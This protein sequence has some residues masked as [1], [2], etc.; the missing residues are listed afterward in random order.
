MRQGLPPRVLPGLRFI[1]VRVWASPATLLGLVLIPL[2]VLPGGSVRVVGGVLEVH[3]GLVTRLLRIGLPWVGPVAALTLGHVVLGC[4]R[5][6]LQ[7][8]RAHERVHVR[9]YERWGPVLIPAYLLAGLF[10]RFRG[11]DPYADNPFEKEAV[12]KTLDCE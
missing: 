10:V 1:L 11:A 5:L 4:D 6:C 9:Q 3:G 7:R 2:A 8:S 12:D